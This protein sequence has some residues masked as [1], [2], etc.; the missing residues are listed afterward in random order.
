LTPFNPEERGAQL[1]LRQHNITAQQINDEL[2]K[3]G[4]VVSINKT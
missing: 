3:N 1:S 2:E 4:I